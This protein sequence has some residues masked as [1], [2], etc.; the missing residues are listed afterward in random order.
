MS[1]KGAVVYH[2]VKLRTFCLE[3]C[4]IG[5]PL[6]WSLRVGGYGCDLRSDLSP[7]WSQAN[8]QSQKTPIPDA[9]MGRAVLQPTR[10]SI[11][12]RG[13]CGHGLSATMDALR[14]LEPEGENGSLACP[15]RRSCPRWPQAVR[16][17]GP[18]SHRT[19]QKSCSRAACPRLPGRGW[20]KG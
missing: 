20:E 18:K 16:R 1:S 14:H 12:I 9:P 3:P 15:H 17:K 13:T 8:T 11:R 10:H 5:F 7:G 4:G 2:S 19:L 6:S